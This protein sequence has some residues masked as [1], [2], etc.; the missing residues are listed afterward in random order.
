[1]ALIPRIMIAA[2]ASGTGKTTMVC[3]LL[4]LLAKRGLTCGA[5][6]VG[7]DYLDPTFHRKLAGAK[8][9]NLDLFFCDKERVRSLLIAGAK[10]CDVSILEGVMGYYDGILGQGTRASSYDV[11]RVTQTPTVL[12]VNA[13][14]S[15]VSIAAQLLGFVKFRED[16]NVRGVILNQCS[17]ALC[18]TIAPVIE[19]ECGVHVYGCVPRDPSFALESRHLGLIGADEVAD[20]EAKLDALACTMEKTV[21]IKGLLNLAK[22]APELE[23]EPWAPVPLTQS[24]P[25]IAV[26]HDAAFSFYYSENLRFLEQLGAELVEFSPLRDKALPSDTCGL[27]LG[28][29]YPEVYV[30]EL[31]GNKDMLDCVQKALRAGLPCVAECGGFMYLQHSLADAAGSVYPMASILPG[32]AQN[33]GNLRHFGYIQMTAQTDGLL[34]DK[35]YELRAHE[36]H[37]WH[38]ADEGDSFAARKPGR[39]TEWG[40]GFHTSSLYAGFPHLYWPGDPMPANRFVLA[41]ADWAEK[42]RGLQ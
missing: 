10:D 36:F 9:G 21:D 3:G 5:F 22:S 33:E 20:L 25:R 32:D 8:T 41:C 18:K 39:A 16:S 15:S 38:S 28:G 12:V 17:E 4:R 19:Q 26:A 34:A 31:S 1:M 6:K 30:K 14:G 35:G 11:A 23:A 7:P 40:A 24:H 42:R 37:Y 27:Y 13:R 2:P 29:G